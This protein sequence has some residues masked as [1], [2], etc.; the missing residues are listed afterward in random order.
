MLKL[1]NTLSR[2]IE[3]FVPLKKNLVGM[4]TCGPTVYDYTH[5]GHL[6]KYINDDILKKTLQANGYSV[7][8]VMNIT[9]VGHLTSDSDTGEDKMEKGALETGRTVWEVAK[10]YEDYFFKSV[11]RVN[12]E[13]P[14][15]VCRA[16]EHIGA[17]IKLIERLEKNGL[18]YVTDHAVYFDVT[19]FPKYGELSGQKL[20]DKEVGARSD[21]FVDK[22]KKHPA[23]FALW[24]FTVGHFKDHTMR[25]SSPWG[26][27]FPGWH[28]ECS[29]MSM[30][31]LGESFDIHTGGI[32][33]IPVHHE[34]EI[35][36]S[37]GATGKQFVK[38]WV[39]HD[40]VN[41][42]HKKMSKSKKNFLKVEEIEGKGYDPMA[43]RYLYLTAHYRSEMAF[44][45]ESLTAAQTALNKLKEEVRGW[46]HS[47]E[48][49][50]DKDGFYEKFLGAVN[51]DLNIPKALAVVWEMVKSDM[52]SAQKAADLIEMDKIL[53][54]E[55]DKVIGQKIEIPEEVQKLIQQREKARLEKDFEISDRLRS[56]IE[57]LGYEVEDLSDGIKVKKSSL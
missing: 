7:H 3:E 50:L 5:I 9:D 29:A 23:D 31:Y 51:E 13:R 43:L 41:I 6:R 17:Q 47:A 52:P 10:F 34:N 28:I 11:G 44:S 15:I 46:S 1:F 12:I 30:E 8:H 57:K 22:S 45:F 19:K 26:E 16:T 35:A 2:K 36:Q 54:L 20:E 38:Y 27:G 18:V 42:D 53:G 39:H 25:W 32:D 56:E 37:E 21:V 55:L 14:D 49:R 48:A 4:Y 24:F 40:F 33:H